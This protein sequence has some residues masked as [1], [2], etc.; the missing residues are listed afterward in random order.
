[1]ILFQ[2]FGT[3]G[4]QTLNVYETLHSLYT[5]RCSLAVYEMPVYETLVTHFKPRTTLATAT[6]Y[7]ILKCCYLF[8]YFRLWSMHCRKIQLK[9]DSSSNHVYNYQ[10]CEHPGQRCDES[11]PCIM[12][13][14]F[15][16]KFCQCSG[17]CEYFIKLYGIPCST[18]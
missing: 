15:C 4:I 18:L 5:K 9:K 3:H 14:N 8:R 6:V 12:A 11:C 2:I 1:M 16:E 17:D 7:F 10:P 13:Q